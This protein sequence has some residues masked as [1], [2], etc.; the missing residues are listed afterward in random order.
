MELTI[1]GNVYKFNFGFGFMKELNDKVRVPVDNIPGKKE[2]IGMRYEIARFLEGSIES[3]VTILDAANK[4]QDPRLTRTAIEDY[5]E[6]PDTDIDD[7][8]EKVTDF[9]SKANV[10]RKETREFLKMMEEAKEKEE[11]EQDQ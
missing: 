10:T 1:N 5:I 11:E 8:S 2:S 7:L 6:D 4:G 3:L 9:L